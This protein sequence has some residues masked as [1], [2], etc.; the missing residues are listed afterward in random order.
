MA[1]IN[2]DD[3]DIEKLLEDVKFQKYANTYT[4]TF[5]DGLSG[6]FGMNAQYW[7]RYISLVDILHKFHSA[8]QSNNFEEKVESWK[9][10]IPWFFAKDGTHYSRYGSYYLKS[11]ELI[12]VT[13]PGAKEEMMKIG[14]S[15]RRN[16]KGVGQAIDLAGE[17]SYMRSAKTVGGLTSFQTRTA[18]V[19]KWVLTYQAKFT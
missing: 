8:I 16:E 3:T 10:M 11:M 7:P 5:L 17:Q 12:D 13:H 9:L 19:R 18:T 6:K 14:V 4:S 2:K 1:Y 15:V